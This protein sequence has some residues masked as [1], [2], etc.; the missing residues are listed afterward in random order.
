MQINSLQGVSEFLGTSWNASSIDVHSANHQAN[1]GPNA[2]CFIS[3]VAGVLSSHAPS[4]SDLTISE[5]NHCLNTTI[6]SRSS[7]VLR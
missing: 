5:A 2:P 6:G 4:G 3:V 1:T 7:L